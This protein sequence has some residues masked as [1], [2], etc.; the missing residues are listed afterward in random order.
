MKRRNVALIGLGVVIFIVASGIAVFFAHRTF[1]TT[2]QQAVAAMNHEERTALQRI[3][4][5][6]RMM[7]ARQVYAT[8]GPPSDDLYFLAKWNGFG[9]SPLS[10]VRVYFVD[11]H[12]RK[13]RWIKL[14]FF[15]YERKL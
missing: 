12:P 2:G 8:L 4:S 3:S 9:G 13:I 7:S 5:I 14:G 11:Q 1:S 10:Q 15:L 6:H